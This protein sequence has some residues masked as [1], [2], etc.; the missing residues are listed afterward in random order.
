MDEKH[1]FEVEEYVDPLENV[2][3]VDPL[4]KLDRIQTHA[5][6]AY[7]DGSFWADDKRGGSGV[8]FQD[9][10]HHH[11]NQAQYFPVTRYGACDSVRCEM[12]ATL[13]AVAK[14]RQ[15]IPDCKYLIIK[16]D[17]KKA[18]ENLCQVSPHTPLSTE[19][20]RDLLLVDW[21]THIQF[22][23]VKLAWVPGH[24][25]A[26]D[27]LIS[28]CREADGSITNPSHQPVPKDKIPRR[29]LT[30]DDFVGNHQADQ[31]ARFGN[32]LG[33]DPVT[34]K[35]LDQI[36]PLAFRKHTSQVSGTC[37]ASP[38]PKS[39][40]YST[41]G[42]KESA[43]AVAEDYILLENMFRELSCGKRH[44][45]GDLGK[46]TLRKLLFQCSPYPYLVQKLISLQHSYL[47]LFESMTD[48]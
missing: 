3:N 19:Q 25:V 43:D 33:G 30:Q 12:Y 39:F 26:P 35:H 40:F 4:E 24:S 37:E 46:E 11:L 28:I 31:L 20:Q 2:E 16:Q 13:L 48:D 42:C 36:N 41:Y 18:M 27:D 21:W 7:A 47:P 23:E 1:I 44:L 15:S 22:L 38:L 45:K 32:K 5:V 29:A 9:K 10:K 34:R 14:T 17:C 6:T 8:F